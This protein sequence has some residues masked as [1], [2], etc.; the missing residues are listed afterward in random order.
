MNTPGLSARY[1]AL[2]EPWVPAARRWLY[3]L[4]HDPECLCFGPGFHNH[5]AIQA[6]ATAFAAFACLAADPDTDT[7]RTDMGRDQLLDTALGLLRF[8]LRGHLAGHGACTDGPRW[9]HSWISALCQARMMH[10]VEAI[11]QALEP[12][13]LDGLREMLLSEADWIVRHHPLV[14]ALTGPD[15]RPES[16]LW[17]GALLCRAAALYPDAPNALDYMERAHE[18]LLN[19]ISVPADA[20][21]GRRVA[22]QTVQERHRGANFFDS[23]ACNHHGYLNVGYI[24]ITLSNIAMLHFFFRGL[25]QPAPESLYHHVADVWPLFKACTFPDGRLL[26]I[27]GDT[28]V[29]YCYCQDYAIPIWLMMRD[30]LGDTAAEAFEAAWLTQV[31]R[32]QTDNPEGAFLGRRLAAMARVSPLYYTRLE[33][34]RAVTL[35]M[36]AC[37]RRRFAEF[38]DRQPAAAPTPPL[39]QWHDSYH[40]ACLVRDAQRTV[41]WVWGAAEPPQ[42]LCLPPD[43]SNLAEWRQNLAGRVAGLGMINEATVL[44]HSETPF[45]G[46]FVTAGR[47][48]W[49]SQKLYAEGEPD[50]ETATE[51]L[52]VA[53]LPDGVTLVGLQRCRTLQRAFLTE[54]KGL[55]L[56]VPN[57]VQN[58]FERTYA[59]DGGGVR[60]RGRD[61]QAA[62]WTPQGG[63]LSIDGHLGVAALYGGPLTL[64]HPAEARITTKAYPWQV[65]THLAG[66]FLFVDQVCMVCEEGPRSYDAG[67]TLFDIGFA[68]LAG[69][70]PDP[71]ARFAAANRQTPVSVDHPDVRAV[72]VA[73][74]DGVPYLVAAN[75]GD[76]AVTVTLPAT[77]ARPVGLPAGAALLSATGDCRLT[78]PAGQAGLLAL[79]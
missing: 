60:L 14:A 35:S 23:F 11:A 58:R 78:L 24:G 63:W 34:D 44:R 71:M 75:L 56:N 51:D 26:R 45:P 39:S 43:G 37:W 18:F 12:R 46:G 66:G 67:T 54:V 22:G 5:W 52:A 15:N 59:W 62:T 30:R 77:G 73:G 64:L 61:G 20:H 16:N 65:H 53:A 49:G 10:G 6:N 32:E 50:V 29:R 13:D 19:A 42:G 48:R 8:T 69:A 36:G 76:T 25:G 17:N 79:G 40:G 38:V 1:R 72:R 41:S 31:A 27:G 7:S 9:G 57:D 21:D 55:M 70:G 33:G 74:A 47:L 28:R 68:V 4:P 2:L 3:R